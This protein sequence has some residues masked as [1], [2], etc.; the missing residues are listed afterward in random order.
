MLMAL[1]GIGPLLEGS[2]T[3]DIDTHVDQRAG[4]PMRKR[5]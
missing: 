1:N 5:S 2:G 3:I 4:E